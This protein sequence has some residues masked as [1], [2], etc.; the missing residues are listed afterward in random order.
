LTASDG[1][2]SAGFGQRPLLLDT[3]VDATRFRGTCYRA[4]NWIHVGQTAGRPTV[5]R[6]RTFTFI[7]WR[8]MPASDYAKISRGKQIRSTN[9][10]RTKLSKFHQ[11]V[12][13]IYCDAT[14]RV[15]CFWMFVT[16]RSLSV[17]SHFKAFQ[18]MGV[19]TSYSEEIGGFTPM[20]GQGT[21][22]ACPTRTRGVLTVL[23]D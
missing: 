8:A 20:W 9:P 18:S 23:F 19:T 6:L 4:A 10:Q 3:L 2:V 21:S 11:G 5:E 17:G 15:G 12:S 7:H 22:Q 1:G 13:Q 16:L 14:A